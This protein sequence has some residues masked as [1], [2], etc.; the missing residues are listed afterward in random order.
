ML[1]PNYKCLLSVSRLSSCPRYGQI[2][3]CVS[4]DRSFIHYHANNPINGPQH[5]AFDSCNSTQLGAFV[6]GR[7]LGFVIMSELQVSASST[8]CFFIFS[9]FIFIFIDITRV[10]SVKSAN[11][12]SLMDKDHFFSVL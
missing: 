12:H 5:N 1:P 4:L 8:W 11:H 3:I 6:C 10:T 2:N 9:I 7:H